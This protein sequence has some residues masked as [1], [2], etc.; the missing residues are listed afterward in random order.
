[1]FFK[2]LRDLAKPQIVAIFDCIKRSDGLPVG[3][4]A[5]A[6]N[7]SYMGVKQYCVDLEK[8]GYL[9]T[10]RRAK[11]TGRP[12]LTYRL[13]PKAQLLFPL[14][15]TELTM[16]ILQAISQLHGAAACEKILFQYFLKRTE[17]YAKKI[18]G[19]SLVERATS[20]ARVRD[21]EGHCAQLEYDTRNGL[22]ITEYHSPLSDLA[23][24]F[25]TVSRMEEAMFARLL[26]TP[27]QRELETT[28][29]LSRITFRI[30]G[31]VTVAAPPS[32]APL[33]DEMEAA[34]PRTAPP[35]PPANRLPSRSVT[36]GIAADPESEEMLLNL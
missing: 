13:T 15:S 36:P 4:I 5:A 12:E 18:K 29:G 33:R 32:T 9:D 35:P 19:K 11:E 24:Q 20:L 2:T 22:R 1:M 7:M 6:L 8:R 14:Q 27:V 28:S 30:H 26:Q 3:D 16:E 34:S 10:W 23:R 25:P 31:V 21:A 17:A